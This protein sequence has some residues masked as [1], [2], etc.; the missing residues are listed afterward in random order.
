VLS[1]A[2]WHHQRLGRLWLA[3]K[4]RLFQRGR[5]RHLRLETLEGMSLV[6][7]P[8]VFNPTLFGSS[9]A[10]VRF[11]P[12]AITAG[13]T[14]LDMGT[15]SGALAVAAA[16]LGARV[17]AVDLSSH[18]VRCARINALLNGVEGRVDV[19]EGDLFSP[20]DDQKFDLILFNPPYYRGVPTK[21]WEMA[22][23]SVDALDRFAHGFSSVLAAGGRALLIMSSETQGLADV[24]ARYPIQ[25]RTL[26]QG[27]FGGEQLMVQEWTPRDSEE[28]P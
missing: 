10:F 22:W 20:V 17:V 14:V 26:W 23:R 13:T 1:T 27:P 2:I 5:H 21:P 8:D 6:V 4:F 7:L 15:G 12:A 24:L 11:L 16:R 3:W 18:A 9:E 25:C 19:R 28:A